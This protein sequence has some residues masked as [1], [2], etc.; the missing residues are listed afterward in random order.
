MVRDVVA[1]IGFTPEA[2]E[3]AM[4]SVAA[5]MQILESSPQLR[6]I[7]V[8]IE[9]SSS[10]DAAEWSLQLAKVA[11]ALAHKIGWRSNST[12]FKLV[13]AA[14]LHDLPLLEERLAKVRDLEKAGESREFT[15]EELKRIRFHPVRAAEYARE[16]N[17]IPADV[18]QILIQ[19]HERPNGT[20]FPR[21][22]VVRYFSPLGALF[23]IAQD[24]LD[25]SKSNKSLTFEDF[26]QRRDLEYGVGIF[27]KLAR[28]LR[29]DIPIV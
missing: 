14:L 5:T 3:I 26:L 18:E 22:L 23:V 8:D 17:Q 20:G 29:D 28:A 19:H 16:F 25:D 21:G 7:L 9:N 24:L 2:Q 6:R 1:Q 12:Y 15:E 13:L 4:T 10:G 11:C 27:R